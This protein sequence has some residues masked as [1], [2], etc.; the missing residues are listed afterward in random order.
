MALA[1]SPALRTHSFAPIRHA[2]P[3]ACDALRADS[4]GL[5]LALDDWLARA[6]EAEERKRSSLQKEAE[7]FLIV[8][9]HGDDKGSAPNDI[10]RK[11]RI[12]KCRK[13]YKGTDICA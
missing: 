13:I 5:G 10:C 1:G 8:S 2:R 11:Y 6:L 3:F 4:A 7:Q 12:K 9:Q